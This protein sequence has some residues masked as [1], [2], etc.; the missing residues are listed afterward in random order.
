MAG[1][2]PGTFTSP[3]LLGLVLG[4]ALVAAVAIWA[5][6]QFGH[7]LAGRHQPVVSRHIAERLPTPLGILVG[8]VVGLFLFRWAQPGLAPTVEPVAQRVAVVLAA[9]AGAWAFVRLAR[10]ALQGAATQRRSLEPTARVGSRLVGLVVYVAALLAILSAYGVSI[11]P[12][13]AGLGIG[14]LAVALA[15]QDTMSNFFAG[16]WIQTER[17]ASPGNYVR[18]EGQN[19]EGF[20]EVVGWRTT[21]I[22]AL[23]GNLI[24]VPNSKLAQATVTDFSLPDPSMSVVMTF[25]MPFDVEPQ[26]AMA[27]LVEE[28]KEAAKVTPGLL[29]SPAPFA[30]A[31]PGFGDSSVGYSLIIKVREFVDQWNAQTAVTQRVWA[32]MQREGIRFAYPTRVNLQGNG[33]D[34]VPDI[35]VRPARR[36]L[37]QP[38]GRDPR[39]IEADQAKQEIAARQAADGKPPQA[40]QAAQA[41]QP[42]PAAAAAPAPTEPSA[43][44]LATGAAMA[45]AVPTTPS[46]GNTPTKATSGKHP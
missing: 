8:I 13:L 32:R 11:T 26:R 38:E 7:L 33:E 5:I 17:P 3:M 41:A 16:L 21:R 29:E 27:L 37:R 40:A 36:P 2:D 42:Q 24:V 34:F 9:A 31:T 44:T 45:A 1:L 25:R 22:R 39:A 4:G 35:A 6:G 46:P 18:V 15:L 28:A 19:V 12:L 23:A 30:N 10:L 14:A 43:A 20:V